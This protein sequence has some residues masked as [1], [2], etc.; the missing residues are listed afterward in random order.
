MTDSM[1]SG[2]SDMSINYNDEEMSLEDAVTDIFGQIQDHIN[3]CHVEIRNMCQLVERDD[4]YEEIYTFY[5]GMVE[6]IDEGSK[7]FRELK[8]VMKQVIGKPPAGWIA[9]EKRTLGAIPEESS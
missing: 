8:K 2:M 4:E 6:H 3:Q 9:P 1:C 7:V 5:A